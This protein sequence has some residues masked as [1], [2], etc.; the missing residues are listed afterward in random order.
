ML[1]HRRASPRSLP[2]AAVVALAAAGCAPHVGEYVPQRSIKDDA[3]PV[4]VKVSAP[5]TAIKTIE[6][7]VPRIPV[8]VA[9]SPEPPASKIVEAPAD[10]T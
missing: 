4:P 7:P 10:E 3:A 6:R 5:R 1:L 9:P 8:S 2:F